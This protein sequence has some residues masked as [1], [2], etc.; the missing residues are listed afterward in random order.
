MSDEAVD[1]NA[2]VGEVVGSRGVVGGRKF[3]EGADEGCGDHAARELTHGAVQG[4]DALAGVSQSF[5]GAVESFVVRRDETVFFRDAGGGCKAGGSG[6]SCGA[7]GEE[8]AT[9]ECIHGTSFV[10]MSSVWSRG[11]A[12]LKDPRVMARMRARKPL[13]AT[14]AT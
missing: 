1:C 4:E 8:L 9:S 11:S 2:P 3:A 12:D 6:D 14:I 7:G 13:S 5:A 10:A